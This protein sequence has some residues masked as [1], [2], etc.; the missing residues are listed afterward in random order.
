MDPQCFCCTTLRDVIF[1]ER[2]SVDVISMTIV[3]YT[4]SGMLG[5]RNIHRI[6]ANTTCMIT[7]RLDFDH[8]RSLQDLY[9]KAQRMR[10]T[11]LA[12][13]CTHSPRWNYSCI[14]P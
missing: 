8:E 6:P 14:I 12:T 4:C 7:N 10:Y 2:C 1:T 13:T 9:M 3:Y 11:H 5:H